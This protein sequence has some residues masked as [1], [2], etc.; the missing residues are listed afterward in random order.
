MGVRKAGC[1]RSATDGP[2]KT[3]A[4]LGLVMAQ[5]GLSA[6]GGY[7]KSRLHRRRCLVCGPGENRVRERETDGRLGR[8]RETGR[9]G[10]AKDFIFSLGAVGGIPETRA[11]RKS[12][13][14]TARLVP[15]NGTHLSARHRR[16]SMTCAALARLE[17]DDGLVS[18]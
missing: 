8:G 6:G 2:S 10:F 11:N 17:S 14:R 13:P 1:G 18:F 4:E 16:N 7:A 9:V 12:T 5:R 15:S 3:T